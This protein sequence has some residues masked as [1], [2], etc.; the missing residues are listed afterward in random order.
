MQFLKIFIDYIFGEQFEIHLLKN[1]EVLEE[2]Q[3]ES[4]SGRIDIFIRFSYFNEY[5]FVAIENKIDA[6]DQ[7]E[8]L[9]RYYA[10]LNLQTSHRD[11]IRLIYLTKYGDMPTLV[12][13]DSVNYNKL[14]NENILRRLSYI[15]DISS[16]INLLLQRDNPKPVTVI[17]KQYL[18][19]IN[20]F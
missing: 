13:I 15:N 20:S 14:L 18:K 10:Y 7:E 1:I 9:I 6:D 16:F 12:S 19:T 5:Y 11:K 2:F 3:A 4:L 17:L 8:Q